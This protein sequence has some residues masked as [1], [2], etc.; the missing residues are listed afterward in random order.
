VLALCSEHGGLPERALEHH[1][2]TARLD[3]SFGMPRL[4]LNLLAR[5]AGERQLAR[6]EFGKA[7]FLLVREDAQRL[8]LFVGGFNREALIAL[9]SSSLAECEV[10]S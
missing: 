2:T 8:V 6:D 10:R 9:C 3:P 7:L 5:R 1:R 4:H